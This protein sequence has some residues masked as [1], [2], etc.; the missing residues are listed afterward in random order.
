M[1]RLIRLWTLIAFC[2]RRSSAASNGPQ[3]LPRTVISWMTMGERSMPAGKAA[4]V[5]A[6]ATVVLRTIVPRGRTRVRAVG[7]P[8]GEPVQSTTMS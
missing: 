3:R 5:E 4:V 7:R 8:V 6:G 1:R 2:V